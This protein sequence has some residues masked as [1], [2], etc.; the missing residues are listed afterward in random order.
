[1]PDNTIKVMPPPACPSC[2]SVTSVTQER[3]IKGASTTLL[4]H[5]MRCDH[6]WPMKASSAA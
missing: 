5:C 6:R 4:W 3:T 1:M 2:G